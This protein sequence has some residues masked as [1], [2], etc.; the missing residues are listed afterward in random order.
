MTKA[1]AVTAMEAGEK[2][3]HVSFMN[4]EH[5]FMDGGEV[6]CE[7]GYRLEKFWSYRETPYFET[8]WEIYNEEKK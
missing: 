6:Y 8:G 1:E 3:T 4:Y 5:V 7:I 2:V